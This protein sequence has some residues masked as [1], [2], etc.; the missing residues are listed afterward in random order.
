MKQVSQPIYRSLCTVYTSPDGEC[1][2]T[3]G[4]E[5]VSGERVIEFPDV[6]LDAEAV[7]RLVDLLQR[8][9]PEPCHFRE[10]VLDYIERLASPR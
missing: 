7:E 6:D 2:W 10:V 3:Y 9:Q 8:W 1:V 4:V 5:M